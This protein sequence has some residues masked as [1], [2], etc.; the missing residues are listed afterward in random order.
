MGRL[1][2]VTA[3]A[4]LLNACALEQ[5]IIKSKRDHAPAE[6]ANTKVVQEPQYVMVESA[7]EADKLLLYYQHVQSL[8]DDDFSR[9]FRAVEQSVE[10]DAER[11]ELMRYA[12]LLA[13]P[14]TPH[15]DADTAIG[16]LERFEAVRGDSD[17]DKILGSLSL[18]LR[19]QM[20]REVDLREA[21]HK[22]ANRLEERDK[23]LEHV[24]NQINALKS[25]EKSIHERETQDGNS[26][27]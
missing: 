14:D 2:I 17:Q 21:K 1:I 10:A 11:P 13:R 12:L 4:L 3:A 24:K 25:I 16:I 5:L 19:Q 20:Q 8:S 27:R 23:Q 22:L 7:S 15:H 18:L 9:E 6:E 26:E